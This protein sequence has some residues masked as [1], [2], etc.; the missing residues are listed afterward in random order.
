M[1][2]ASVTLAPRLMPEARAVRCADM[3]TYLPPLSPLM[4]TKMP[5]FL[6][7]LFRPANVTVTLLKSEKTTSPLFRG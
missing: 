6:W 7:E 1:T 3:L 5:K 4:T 2:F